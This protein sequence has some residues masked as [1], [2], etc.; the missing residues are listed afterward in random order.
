MQE[1]D[2]MKILRVLLVATLVTVLF[3][4]PVLG[5]GKKRFGRGKSFSVCDVRKPYL[6]YVEDRLAYVLDIPLA[7][8]S[9]ICGPVVSPILKWF[10]SAEKSRYRYFPWR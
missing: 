6:A 2:S 3:A 8:M 10:E 5:N 1:T 9:P 7:L 4:S